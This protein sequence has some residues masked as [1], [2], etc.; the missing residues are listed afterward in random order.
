MGE[1]PGF[2]RGILPV[3][4][5]RQPIDMQT[6]GQASLAAFFCFAVSGIM[7]LTFFK[8]GWGDRG[9]V[10][11]GLMA[12]AAVGGVMLLLRA[13]K[14][15]RISSLFRN[16]FLETPRPTLRP[17][18]TVSLRLGLEPA[19][20]LEIERVVFICEQI[21]SCF[22]EGESV[23]TETAQIFRVK[24][25]VKVGKRLDVDKE[26]GVECKLSLPEDAPATFSSQ[27]HRI[28]CQVTAYIEGKGFSPVEL[29][30]P[31]EVAPELD[32][33]APNLENST[34]DFASRVDFEGLHLV[35]EQGPEV[36]V[37]RPLGSHLLL[38]ADRELD[39]QGISAALSWT[40]EGGTPERFEVAQAD[41]APGGTLSEGE[42]RLD[43][44]LA[45]P[46]G[47]PATH[48]G[49]LVSVRW[50]LR[51][52]IPGVVEAAKPAVLPV[53]VGMARPA[54]AS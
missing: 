2:L 6:S 50:S 51:V 24:R 49:D 20:A 13:R 16:V 46:E 12:V 14:L 37:G 45:I 47:A 1:G 28:A 10:M 25:K 41:L 21:E 29:T 31:I 22:L 53:R 43:L 40:V 9:I 33:R 23:H 4:V 27:Y 54:V 32:S 19:R 11:I 35:L 18:E 48:L 7:S 30:W 38:H 15:A 3:S 44:D 42:T 36:A 26:H 39:H 17:G 34:G 8:D 5:L 52:T